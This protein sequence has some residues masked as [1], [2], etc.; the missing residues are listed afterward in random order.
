M[1]SYHHAGS[2][3]FT[4]CGRWGRERAGRL[5]VTITNGS[6]VEFAYTGNLCTLLFDLHGLSVQPQ[7]VV[8]LDAQG[9]TRVEI[10]RD[11][12]V[13]LTPVHHAAPLDGPPFPDVRTTCHHVRCM[14]VMDSDYLSGVDNWT[15]QQGAARFAGAMLEAGETIV[16]IPQGTRFIECFGDSI[17]AGLRVLYTSRSDTDGPPCQCPERNWPELLAHWLGFHAIVTGHGGQ[18]ITSA[19]TGGVPPAGEAFEWVYAGEPWDPPTPPRMAVIYH[20]ANDSRLS[21]SQYKRYL[22]Q[23]RAAYPDSVMFAFVPHN[24]VRHREPIQTAHMHKRRTWLVPRHRLRRS[25]TRPPR[26]R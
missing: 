3:G 12:A 9:P 6:T 18:G 11:G 8:W 7:V 14:A 21:A 17:T 23:V 13:R 1:S 10:P 22:R 15:L 4:Y 25:P 2:E 20:G 26:T 19:G 24:Q 16:P 5:A